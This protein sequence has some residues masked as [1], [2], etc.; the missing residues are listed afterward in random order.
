MRVVIISDI[1]F[2]N[3]ARRGSEL[4]YEISMADKEISADI[5]HYGSYLLQVQQEVLR[6]SIEP[7]SSSMLVI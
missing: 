7:V 5:V 1:M 3:A 4:G 6:C 2:A